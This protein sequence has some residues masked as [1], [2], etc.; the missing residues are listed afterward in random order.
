MLQQHAIYQDEALLI[1]SSKQAT[2]E[3]KGLF[4][5]ARA[6]EPKARKEPRAAVT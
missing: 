1:Q 4:E 5:A 2:D 6:A 3:L